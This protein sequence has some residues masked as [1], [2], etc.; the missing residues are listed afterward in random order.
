M[1]DDTDVSWRRNGASKEDKKRALACRAM[2]HSRATMVRCDRAMWHGRA[3]LC[4]GTDLSW[5]LGFASM[6]SIHGGYGSSLGVKPWSSKPY[7]KRL[8]LGSKINS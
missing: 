1:L 2:W 6:Y 8:C 3:M 4:S 7:I 5:S